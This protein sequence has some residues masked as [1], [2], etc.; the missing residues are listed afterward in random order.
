MD[1][2]AREALLWQTLLVM[3]GFMIVLLVMVIMQDRR[4]RKAQL[5]NPTKEAQE[6]KMLEV[7]HELEDVIHEC[8]RIP[9]YESSYLD[10]VLTMYTIGRVSRVQLHNAIADWLKRGTDFRLEENQFWKK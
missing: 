1:T 8:G 6:C 4:L 2:C 3:G 10:P 9:L 7:A 5:T